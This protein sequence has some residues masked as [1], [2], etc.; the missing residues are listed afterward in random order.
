M[1]PSSTQYVIGD[2]WKNNSRKNKGVEPM[3]KQHPVMDG[4]GNTSRSNVIKSNI[5]QESGMLGP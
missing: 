4:T 5:A 2:Q 3:Q 1:N